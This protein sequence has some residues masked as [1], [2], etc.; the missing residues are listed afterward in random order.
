MSNHAALRQSVL[1]ALT[2]ARVD[3]AA[4]AARVAARLDGYSGVE[5]RE[6]GR[7]VVLVTKEG[8]MAC[9]DAIGYLGGEG[10]AC[11]PLG[12]EPAAGLA[13]AAADHV[14]DVGGAGTCAHEGTR[15]ATM[16]QR[17]ERYGAWSGKI[18]ECLWYG[19]LREGVSGRSIGETC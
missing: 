19:Q 6:A 8:A 14:A 13:L 10:V 3:P 17:D 1:E 9:H 7:S 11:G 2:E 12:A 16:V 18:G 5:H 15:G 4:T